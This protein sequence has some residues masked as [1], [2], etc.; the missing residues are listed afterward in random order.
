LLHWINALLFLA[1]LV[2][3]LLIYIPAVKVPAVD[4]YR[5]VPLLHI[6]FG[7]SWILSPLALV[8][9]IRRRAS[10]AADIAGTL[11]PS[12]G[13][14]VW[15]RY[16][17]LALLGARVR[18]PRTGKFN[19]G[20]KLNSWYWL[21][22]SVAL[23]MTGLVLAVN[24]FSKSIFEASFVEQVFPLHEV[25]ALLSL[26]PLAGHLYFA[27]VNRSTRPALLGIISGEVD[28]AWAREHHAA[29]YEE[30][31]TVS[32]PPTPPQGVGE[33]RTE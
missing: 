2:S 9:L 18:Q 28:A 20:Q 13:D 5:L 30:I 22:A 8:A 25:I 33:G 19:A 15:L 6:V 7:V 29:W 11:T 16:A 32:P 17:T 10:L 21:L 12:A 3:G 31:V 14:A 1:L 23:A 26:I 24:F 27:V 4:G